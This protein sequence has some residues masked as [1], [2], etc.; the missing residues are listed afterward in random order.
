[1]TARR[2]LP[3]TLI[4]LLLLSATLLPPRALAED[5]SGQMPSQ[6]LVYGV[7]PNV[8]QFSQQIDSV[9]ERMQLPAPRLLQMLKARLNLNQG[10]PDT[11]TVA[12][13][14]VQQDGGQGPMPVI[15]V[16]TDNYAQ[17][18]KSFNAEPEEG[19]QEVTIAGSPT[20]IAQRGDFALLAPPR[21]GEQLAEIAAAPALDVD[22]TTRD[23]TADSGAYLV[24]PP[25][26][27]KQL[28]Q[29]ALVGLQIIKRQLEQT[30]QAATMTA[31]LSVYEELFQWTA[32]E[33]DRVLLRLQVGQSGAIVLTK[34]VLF[35]EPWEAAPAAPGAVTQRLGRFPDWPYLATVA[36]GIGDSA[37]ME[38]WM[39]LS[40]NMMQGMAG[41][42][43]LTEQQQ[44]QLLAASRTSMEGVRGMS[45]VF[46]VPTEGGSIYSR[47]AMLMDVENA[48]KY[49]SNYVDAMQKMQEIFGEGNKVPY[50]IVSSEK[51]QVAG[52]QGLKV[53]MQINPEAMG[54]AGQP[55]QD[56]FD[57]MYGEGGKVSIF[58]VP[59][60]PQTVAVAYAEDSLRE[61]LKAA[62]TE[63]Q[64]LPAG[65]GIDAT[66]K[67]LPADAALVAY[68]SPGGAVQFAQRMMQTLLPAEQR[69]QVPQIPD[70]P[71]SPPLGMS[72]QVEDGALEGSL[73]VPAELQSAIGQYIQKVQQAA[74]Q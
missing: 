73:V 20:A 6:A 41:Q 70:F 72:V 62:R 44:E 35:E 9:A 63:R 67:L 39:Q 14:L 18:L 31:G 33:V 47:M 21:F 30:P 46:G 3:R 65:T 64:G 11:G 61:L 69:Q 17:L 57:K 38:K 2:A 32:E 28:S 71:M 24:I 34:R 74:A 68:V 40:M 50:R 15:F 27:V 53:V 25:S 36:T 43:Q 42:M 5:V 16:Q 45:M 56:I 37:A 58:M 19:V 26:G 66:A 59:A 55:A 1:M 51:T 22:E 48:D 60:N 4:L 7:I 8:Q 52:M 13:A 29:Q 49:L 23:F 12:I 10:M 54:L